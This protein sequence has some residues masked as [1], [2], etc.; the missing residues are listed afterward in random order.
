MTSFNFIFALGK[1]KKKKI[2]IAHFVWMCIPGPEIQRWVVYVYVKKKKNSFQLKLISHMG[3]I[4]QFREL[5]F[6]AGGYKH[7]FNFNWRT[8]DKIFGG[9]KKNNYAHSN[10]RW[11]LK[12]ILKIPAIN[13]FSSHVGLEKKKSNERK[14]KGREKYSSTLSREN[15]WKI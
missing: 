4:F 1:K 12:L 15:S 6:E 8:F 5:V 9:G 3:E 14:E 10:V 2:N 11:S 13:Y 7:C